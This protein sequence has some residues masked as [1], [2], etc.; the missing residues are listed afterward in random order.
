MYSKILAQGTKFGSGTTG[1][2][3]PAIVTI[4]CIETKDLNR[5]LRIISQ[6]K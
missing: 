5:K 1:L 2:D 6:L 3:H 4:D